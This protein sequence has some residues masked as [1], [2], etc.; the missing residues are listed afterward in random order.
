[1][2]ENVVESAAKPEHK[3]R[4]YRRKGFLWP[5]G[6][7]AGLVV[8]GL[9][10]VNVSPW[11]GTMVIRKVFEMDANKTTTAL[12]KHAPAG[13][14]LIAN[15]QYR[16][17]D[18]DAYLDVYFP[19]ATADGAALPTLIWTHGGAWVSGSKSNYN[20]YYQLLANEGYAV[21]SL[22]YSVGPN[23][24]YPTA[25][26]QLND[27]HAYVVANAERLHVDPGNIILAGD[28]AGSQL[29]SQLATAITSPDYASEL[30][31]TPA[32]KPEQLRGIVLNCGIFDMPRMLEGGGI[33]GWGIDQSLW[34]YTGDRNLGKSAALQQMSTL[35]RVTG[36]YPPAYISGGNG[37]PLTDTQSKPLAEK[38]AGLGVDV[39][40]LFFPADY[41]PKLPHEYQFNIDN[42]GGQQALQQTIDFLKRTFAP[43]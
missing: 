39:T 7:V 6:V 22:G 37:D 10:A 20:G 26:R 14:T 12:D 3:R 43:A 28:S 21:V 17:G 30:G 8:A 42:A 23:Q 9:V 34:A 1:M 24:T 16:N 25:V 29:S 40:T 15:Q 4:F 2:D 33:I 13:I 11:P 35:D 41:E 18:P 38:L 5:V 36:D 19:E 27:A 32:L 31:I